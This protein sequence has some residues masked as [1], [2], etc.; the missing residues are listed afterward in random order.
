MNIGKCKEKLDVA[1]SPNESL[2]DIVACLGNYIE[3]VIAD[4]TETTT[5]NAEAP[6]PNAFDIMQAAQRNRK[7]LP[8][9]YPIVRDNNKIR[10]KNDILKWLAT[11]ELGWAPD[12]CNTQ[13][14]K[15]VETLANALWEVDGHHST[16]RDRGCGIPP[17]FDNFQN[18]RKPE[19]SKHRK[20]QLNNFEHRTL[21]EISQALF[22]LTGSSYFK[23]SVWKG[24]HN[25]LLRLA[26][27]LRKY[28][29]YLDQH[30]SACQSV[31]SRKQGR[32]DVDHW[33]VYS[34]MLL[35]NATKSARYK[36]LHDALLHAKPYEP[37]FLNDYAPTDRR[38]KNEYVNELV[39]PCKM[40]HY[41][42]TG[43]HTYLHF[44]WKLDTDDTETQRQQ[45][46]DKTKEMLKRQVSRLP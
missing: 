21:V 28:A 24:V 37:V 17:M 15:F 19:K 34:A 6:A 12:D 4:T 26:D 5:A 43:L 45:K 7:S 29:S 20:R 39:F 13:G 38:R 44:V 22:Q 2:A 30:L 46:N 11:N 1:V 10:M 31:H 8:A 32:T 36:N 41:S 42:Y 25:G 27:N 14:H 23:N 3:F 40:M 33:E 16:L 18:Y 35:I 9:Q